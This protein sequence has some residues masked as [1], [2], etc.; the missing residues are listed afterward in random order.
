[1]MRG[2]GCWASCGWSWG[3]GG[4]GASAADPPGSAPSLEFREQSGLSPTRPSPIPPLSGLTWGSSLPSLPYQQLC[5]GPSDVG[6]RLAL[7]KEHV[8]VVQV[9]TPRAAE[10]GEVKTAVGGK[11][12]FRVPQAVRPHARTQAPARRGRFSK[13]RCEGPHWL[14][15]YHS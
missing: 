8:S 5:A 3:V 2:L 10:G 11:Q 13:T 6:C 14:F 12:V 4:G 15:G 1:M 9:Q 7:A